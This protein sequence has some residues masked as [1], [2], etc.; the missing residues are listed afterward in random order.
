MKKHA[1]KTVLLTVLIVLLVLCMALLLVGACIVAFVSWVWGG[2]RFTPDMAIEAV[3]LNASERESIAL[4]GICFYYRCA[5]GAE[6]YISD[7]M[8][9]ERNGIGMW[10]A[11]T[12]PVD[13][14]PL[15]D[16]QTG[17]RIGCI[18]CAENGGKWH[19][20]LIFDCLSQYYKDTPD[21]LSRGFD[22]IL[23]DGESVDVFKHSYFVTDTA[24]SELTIGE[25]TLVVG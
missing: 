17:E 8:M 10:Y 11:V 21:F 6:D 4:D 23:A 16:K 14:Y 20:F 18:V 7:V 5:E 19:S 25:T 24:P 12:N 1:I 3:S 13:D 22:S 15:Y 2:I 9:V